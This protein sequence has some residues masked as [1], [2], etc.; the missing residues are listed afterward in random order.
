MNTVLQARRVNKIFRM[1]GNQNQVLKSV[2]LDINKG[3][4]LSVMGPSGSG[5]ST[6]MY[7]ISGMDR[8]TS[9][10]VEFLGKKI[11]ELS[12]KEL[13]RLR[14]TKM[15]FIFQ[16]IHLLKNLSIRDNIIVSAL[17]SKINSK[18]VVN[19]R[20]DDLMHRT[21]IHELGN[22][23]ITQAS[24]GQLQ[25]AAICRA[26]IN[27]PEVVFGD[28]PTGALNSKASKEI[29][30]ILEEINRM[31]TTVVL[32]THDIKVAARTRRVIFLRD[33][34]LVGEY[35]HGEEELDQKEKEEF[36]HEWLLAR[37]F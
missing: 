25:R 21:G 5:K 27:E 9:G 15:G 13:A 20:A 33:G 22:N 1:N 16:Q 23:S 3:D 26:L 28:E 2:D 35:N 4:F 30:D 37:G 10:S 11:E 12:E 19:K 14:L 8:M 24:G 32:V 34:E 17:L 36:L 7:N 29:M 18:E 6:L 31:G